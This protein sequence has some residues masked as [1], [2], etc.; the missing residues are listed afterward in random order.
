LLEYEQYTRPFEIDNMKVPDV[1]ISGNH[2]LIEEYRRERSIIKTFIN[3]SDMF[4]NIDLTKKDIKTIFNYLI[5][6]TNKIL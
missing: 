5:D 2:K 1:L 4:K 6:K 3:R